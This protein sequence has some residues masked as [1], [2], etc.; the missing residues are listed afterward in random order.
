[1]SHQLFQT[2]IVNIKVKEGSILVHLFIAKYFQR[3]SM[4]TQGKDKLSE[5][6]ITLRL[7]ESGTM[8]QENWIDVLGRLCRLRCFH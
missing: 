6:E 1:M 2:G 5:Y 7:Q 4:L 3:L 8:V